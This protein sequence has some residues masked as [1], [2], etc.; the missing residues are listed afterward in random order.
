[1]GGDGCLVSAHNLYSAQDHD[2]L[3]TLTRKNHERLD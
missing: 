3:T 1:M 2:D